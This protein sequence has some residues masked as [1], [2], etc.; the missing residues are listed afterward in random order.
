MCAPGYLGLLE[1]L[2]NKNYGP[3]KVFFCLVLRKGEFLQSLLL[4]L[5][6]E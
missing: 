4:F 5:V 1:D 3:G 6:A 2:L